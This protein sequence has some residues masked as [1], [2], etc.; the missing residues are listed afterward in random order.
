MHRPITPLDQGRFDV[1]LLVV[2]RVRVSFALSG[3]ACLLVRVGSFGLTD[4][5][6]MPLAFFATRVRIGLA[7]SD[8][9]CLPARLVSTLLRLGSVRRWRPRPAKPLSLPQRKYERAQTSESWANNWFAQAVSVLPEA[10]PVDLSLFRARSRDV[11]PVPRS[12]SERPGSALRR[13]SPSEERLR[14]A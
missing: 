7:L 6:A 14:D 5:W 1:F 4:A 13:V 11:R 3:T 12:Q 2:A 10:Q 9:F 8:I